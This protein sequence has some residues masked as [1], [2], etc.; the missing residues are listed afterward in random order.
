MIRRQMHPIYGTL[1][2]GKRFISARFPLF[3]LCFYSKE[4]FY[5]LSMI[6]KGTR[7]D[8]PFFIMSMMF[9]YMRLLKLSQ[10]RW[11]M[12]LQPASAMAMPRGK[13]M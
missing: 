13:V 3:I 7:T 10:L 8:T 2:Y 11:S 12:V 6:S 4:S 1:C 5:F 9:G